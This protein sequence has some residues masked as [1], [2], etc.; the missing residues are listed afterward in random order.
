[1]TMS[2]TGGCQ[3][4]AIRYA[5]PVRPGDAHLCHC[6]MCQKAV[7]G[8]FAALVG[9][10]AGEFRFTRGTPSAFRSSAHVE[11]GFCAACGTPLFYRETVEGHMSV[12]IGSL[13]D[14]QAM[15]PAFQVGTEARMS[16]FD[17]LPALRSFGATEDGD[18]AE[19]ADA[20][21]ASN[22]QHPDHETDVWPREA[23]R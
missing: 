12:T 20:I 4:G 23:T 5:G 11:R 10:V 14:P 8:L 17:A 3:C 1:M 15:M 18:P 16:W 7:G 9:T 19:V 22:R 21:K 2:V 13:D 6:R